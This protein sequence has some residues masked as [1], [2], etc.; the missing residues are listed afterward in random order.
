MTHYQQLDL[1]KYNL[2]TMTHSKMIEQM[3]KWR[4]MQQLKS[5]RAHLALSLV[6]A[7]DRQLKRVI[8]DALLRRSFYAFYI[9][10]SFYGQPLL[11]SFP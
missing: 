8:N 3:L 11:A 7:K 2:V 4:Q 10:Q 5:A 9:L 6:G 1:K